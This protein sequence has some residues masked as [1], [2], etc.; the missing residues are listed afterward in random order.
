MCV[1]LLACVCVYLHVRVCVCVRVCVREFH[2][3]VC[4][5]VCGCVP[6]RGR[7]CEC[8]RLFLLSTICWQE[9]NKCHSLSLTT[10]GVC[11]CLF[12]SGTSRLRVMMFQ[13]S[14]YM[15]T[16]MRICMCVCLSACLHWSM[17]MSYTHNTHKYASTTYAWVHVY[18][19]VCTCHAHTRHTHT[20]IHP[21]TTLQGFAHVCSVFVYAPSAGVNGDQYVQCWPAFIHE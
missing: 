1:S 18:T 2:V 13:T 17:Y 3:S 12:G 6:A 5:H 19:S 4:M 10:S 14:T 8:V 7:A 9:S 16:C 15:G 21:H 20:H 11:S